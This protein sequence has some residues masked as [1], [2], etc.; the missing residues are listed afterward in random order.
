MTGYAVP[1]WDG[2]TLDAILAEVPPGRVLRIET[3]RVWQPPNRVGLLLFHVDPG[4]P[5]RVPA[6]LC[7][8]LVGEE[9]QTASD[10]LKMVAEAL[11]LAEQSKT[12]G[13]VG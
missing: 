1:D 2:K 13:A 7:P 10:L 6:K 5:R 11:A 9:G 3:V 8:M 4:A 12:Q